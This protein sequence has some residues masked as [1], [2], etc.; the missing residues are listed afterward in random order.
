[1]L[2]C[3]KGGLVISRHNKIQDALSDLASQALFPSA[4]RN[5]PR[6]NSSHPAEV[7]N[8]T[9]PIPGVKTLLSNRTNKDYGGILIQGSWAHGT[10]CI[11]GVCITDV[12]AKSNH[13]RAPGTVLAE[14]EREKKKKYL[15]PCLKQRWH[16]TPFV[17]STDGI[18]D[19]EAKTLLKHLSALLSEKWEKPYSEVCGYVNAQISIAI[20]QATH[21]CLRGSRNPTSHMSNRHPQWE[22]KASLSLYC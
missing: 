4:V 19:K 5:E 3:K 14:H 12:N 18:L 10:D 8:A 13:S 17:V 2:S 1:V 15:E 7:K 9:E 16:F 20:V 22:D 11:I 21:L 6:I